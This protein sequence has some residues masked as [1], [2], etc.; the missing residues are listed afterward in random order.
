MSRERAAALV[1]RSPGLVPSLAAFAVLLWFAADEGGFR[2]TT[3]MPATLLLG[4][5]LIACL[6]LLPRPRPARLALA[7]ILLLAGYGAFCLLSMLW[8][9][10]PELAWDAGNR[11]LL[12]AV[13]LAL[14]ALWP[15]RGRS[16]AFLL[17]GYGLG[18]A[19][20]ALIEL[21]KTAGADLSVQYFDEARFAHPVGY[22][23]A[24]VGLWMLGLLP[25]GVLAGR[26]GVPAPLRGCSWAPRAC[27]PAPRSSARAVA[28]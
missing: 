10:Q 27:S 17:G 5:L 4:V 13:L 12:Y 3:W 23:N 25:C 2:G 11:T 9:E 28:G 18:V 15:L 16:A 7:A 6:A 8:A 26:R 19:A 24:N 21:L 20:I 1:A 14:C 22:T